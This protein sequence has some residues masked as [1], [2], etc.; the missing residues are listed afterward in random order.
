MIHFHELK[1]NQKTPPYIQTAS[2]VKRLILL[3]RAV[4]GDRMPSRR[5]LAAQLNLNPNTVQKAYKLMEEEGFVRTCGNQGSEIYVD[6]SIFQKIEEELTK[7]LVLE[8]IQSAK[9]V[10][11]SFKKVVDLLSD[12]WE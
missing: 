1:L 9:E 8:F 7:E 11:L 5:E 2:Y 3:G 10:Q 12:H 4:S 6:E